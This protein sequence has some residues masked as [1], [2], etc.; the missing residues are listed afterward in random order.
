[1]VS[2]LSPRGP[3]LASRGILKPDIIGPGVNILPAWPLSVED[4]KNSKLTFNVIL[5]TSMSCPYLSG[6][7][8]LLT[9]MH[10]DWSPA[11][12]K[13]AIMTTVELT[14]LATNLGHVNPSRT[15]NP[16]LVY[17][18]EPNDYIPYLC[19]LNYI[20]LD[21][22]FNTNHIVKCSKTYMRT[23]TN[24]GEANSSYHS[25]IVA[26]LGVNVTLNTTRLE[27][28]KVNQ[29]MTYQVTF[30][31]VATNEYASFI[32][33]FL[34]WKSSNSMQF[35]RTPISV[36]LLKEEEADEAVCSFNGVWWQGHLLVV[37][38][39]TILSGKR[40]I[41]RKKKTLLPHSL[42]VKELE[43]Q[44][45][46]M[47]GSSYYPKAAVKVDEG[48]DESNYVECFLS[49]ETGDVQ[50]AKDDGDHINVGEDVSV[51]SGNVLQCAVLADDLE[52]LAPV[53]NHGDDDVALLSQVEDSFNV[54]HSMNGAELRMLEAELPNVQ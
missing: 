42:S 11:A 1:M 26:L 38:R 39:A 48:I 50:G 33:G 28:S 15:I 31:W 49:E 4:K 25:V 40:L 53:E 47:L 10:F 5:G 22:Y 7:I 6:I 36:K 24:V 8:P 20:V 43:F 41:W 29:K 44:K 35:V 16:G 9:K 32:H 2:S 34:M 13:F 23:V 30:S 18:P 21:N 19:N 51:H 46:Y 14:N 3:S 12:I 37:K 54:T 45:I 27:F 52:G 17:D